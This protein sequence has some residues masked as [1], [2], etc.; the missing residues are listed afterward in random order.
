MQSFFV[1]SPFKVSNVA[2]FMLVFFTCPSA[3]YYCDILPRD[4]LPRDIMSHSQSDFSFIECARF[5]ISDNNYYL[6]EKR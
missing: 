2:A 1:L 4:M 3:L 5:Y 6:R